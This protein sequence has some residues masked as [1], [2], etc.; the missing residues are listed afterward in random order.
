MGDSVPDGVI[1][2]ILK[3]KQYQSCLE[4][5]HI[6]F[7]CMFSHASNFHCAPQWSGDLLH[8]SALWQ[9]IGF[10][11]IQHFFWTYIVCYTTNGMRYVGFQSL[12]MQWLLMR[13][14]LRLRLIR[15]VTQA[16]MPF[17]AVYYPLFGCLLM[18]CMSCRG[19]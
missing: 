1:A 5:G 19:I 10:W 16:S 15:Y 7:P 14:L 9:K 11:W 2:A 8:Y 12:G 6:V 18:N 17:N 4:S 3:S 13:L